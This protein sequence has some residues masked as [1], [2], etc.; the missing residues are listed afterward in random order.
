M[1]HAVKSQ[2]L[3]PA[4]VMVLQVV[5]EQYDQKDLDELR[6]LLLDFN[7]RKMQQH[8]NETVAQKKYTSADFEKMLHGH[9]RITRQK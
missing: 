6:D 2:S 3:T 5:K 1:K 4:Q 8:L 9:D 7:D